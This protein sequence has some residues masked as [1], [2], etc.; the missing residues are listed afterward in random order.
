M[1]AWLLQATL[2]DVIISARDKLLTE[3]PELFMKDRS[4]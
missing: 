4:V 2:A 3:R 1:H